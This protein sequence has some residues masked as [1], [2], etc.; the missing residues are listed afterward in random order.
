MKRIFSTLFLLIVST[1]IFAQT[2]F[3]P[4]GA[5][6]TY[7]DIWGWGY[8]GVENISTYQCIAADSV[9]GKYIKTI[10]HIKKSQNITYYSWGTG[11]SNRETHAPV[12]DSVY[13]EHDTLFIFN[14]TFNTY[15]PL[16]VFNAQE[17]DT[18][19]VPLLDTL[20]HSIFY[21]NN[22]YTFSY[23]IDSIRMVDYGGIQ[24][25]TFFTSAY[26][27]GINWNNPNNHS[28]AIFTFKPNLN[29][30]F[31]FQHDIE[32]ID[33]A[34]VPTNYYRFK[35]K[36]GYTRLFGGAGQGL[37]PVPELTIMTSP[38]DFDVAD[39][40]ITCYEDGS[41]SFNRSDI[42]C[43]A[44]RYNTP[45]TLQNVQH[46]NGINIYPNPSKDGRICIKAEKMF[47]GGARLWIADILG[48]VVLPARSIA[49]KEDMEIDLSHLTTGVYIIVFE[50]EGQRY[51]YKVVKGE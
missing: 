26:D 27:G 1:T 18:I 9:D 23:I 32:Y 37:K 2:E 45:S 24:L 15:T 38:Y 50:D 19:T 46:L 35:Y 25:E 14:R 36:G 12:T 41:I 43:E 28:N 49:H 21:L 17:G 34:G 22:D 39:N 8:T 5:K 33:S 6:W 20:N 29:W 47:S 44:F 11:Y 30:I 40:P 48:K 51:Y 42:E 3:A 4:L 7:K 16:F 31:H 13:E 10:Q